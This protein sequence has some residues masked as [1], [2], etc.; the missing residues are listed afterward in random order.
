MLVGSLELMYRVC[1]D[2][3]WWDWRGNK[4]GLI[5]FP[6]LPLSLIDKVTHS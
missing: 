5:E 4:A 3:G 1:A 2:C 6:I